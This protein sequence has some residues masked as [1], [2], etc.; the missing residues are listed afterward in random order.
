MVSCHENRILLVRLVCC[1]KNYWSTKFQW[2]LPQQVDRDSSIYV[3]D[4]KLVEFMT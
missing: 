4:I 2:S 1:L 3:L